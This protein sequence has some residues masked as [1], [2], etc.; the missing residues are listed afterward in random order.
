LRLGI[1][2]LGRVAVPAQ[3]LFGVAGNPQAHQI[4]AR[5]VE[6]R[7]GVA[8]RRRQQR[9]LECLA[10]VLRHPPAFEVQSAQSALGFGIPLRR[11]QAKPT[12]GASVILRNA[13][14]VQVLQAAV[15]LLCGVSRLL[16]G[17]S[18]LLGDEGKP[19]GQQA[20]KE[21]NGRRRRPRHPS[22]ATG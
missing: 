2:L 1:A 20:N 18:L 19:G 12:G 16:R 5:Q 13:V 21:T 22:P 7:L 10:V 14:A 6:L 9:P 11:R 15:V 8:L 3:S 17:R 4:Q